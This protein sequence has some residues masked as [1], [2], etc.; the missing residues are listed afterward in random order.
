M[1]CVLLGAR[2]R[3]ITT[4]IFYNERK[5][6]P[7]LCALWG[8]QVL[9]LQCIQFSKAFG[10][11]KKKKAARAPQVN[12]QFPK[13]FGQEK[14]KT[15]ACAP[16]VNWQTCTINLLC[17]RFSFGT[18]STFRMN[19]HTLKHQQTNKMNEVWCGWAVSDFVTCVR[20]IF[21]TLGVLGRW[22]AI[23]LYSII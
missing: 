1:D 2:R 20:A 16:R 7:F 14:K 11:K 5:R 17:S 22:D 21:S 19:E 6:V 23:Y 9:Q 12:C 10:L 3:W 18:S 15:A 8:V 4:L 13:T